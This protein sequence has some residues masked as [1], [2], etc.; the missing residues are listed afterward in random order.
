MTLRFLADENTPRLVT[1]FLRDASYDVLWAIESMV[2]APD[3]L[4]ASRVYS[5]GRILITQDYDFSN[6]LRRGQI[7]LIGLLQLELPQMTSQFKAQRVLELVQL[8][9]DRLSGNIVVVEPARFRV[10]PLGSP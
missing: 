5:D 7:Q 1:K 8:Y 4:I 6:L 10:A 2:G 3:E 9:P